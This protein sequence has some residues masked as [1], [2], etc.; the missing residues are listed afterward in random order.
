M[1]LHIDTN[2]NKFSKEAINTNTIIVVNYEL[3]EQPKAYWPCYT[4]K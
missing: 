4:F 3:F 1:A 2:F